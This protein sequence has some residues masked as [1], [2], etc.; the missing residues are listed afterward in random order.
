[1]GA[2]VLV[3]VVASLRVTASCHSFWMTSSFF[4]LGGTTST[5]CL[6]C[7]ETYSNAELGHSFMEPVFGN[8]LQLSWAQYV[9]V[10]P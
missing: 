3:P 6:L 9:G 8:H 4:D 10:H 1:M 7:L 5:P 2:A